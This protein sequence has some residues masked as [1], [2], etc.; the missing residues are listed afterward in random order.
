MG[1]YPTGMDKLGVRMKLKAVGFKVQDLKVNGKKWDKTMVNDDVDTMFIMHEKGGLNIKFPK[2][3]NVGSVKNIPTTK[4]LPITASHDMHIRV[5]DLDATTQTMYV[6]YLFDTKNVP[7]E[8]WFLYDPDVTEAEAG[9]SDP[10]AEPEPEPEAPAP[11][12][13]GDGLSYTVAATAISGAI[14]VTALLM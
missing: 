1:G 10:N 5:S 14:A 12:T 2:R 11:S 3:Y 9:T 6:D 7:A 13:A 8:T 4:I